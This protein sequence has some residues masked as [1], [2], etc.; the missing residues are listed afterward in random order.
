MWYW[1]Q[2]EESAAARVAAER[3][4]GVGKKGVES[5]EAP[6]LTSM[7]AVEKGRVETVGRRKMR[8][9]A[10]NLCEQRGVK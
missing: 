6:R 2:A 5:Q 4:G 10:M 3:D 1:I 9:K 7:A 8:T